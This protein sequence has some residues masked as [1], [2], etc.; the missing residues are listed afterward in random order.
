[1]MRRNFH[2]MVEVMVKKAL[3]VKRSSIVMYWHN[4]LLSLFKYMVFMK[5]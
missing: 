4:C 2:N 1:M 5:L 3:T